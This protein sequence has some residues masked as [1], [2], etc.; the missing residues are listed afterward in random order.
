[1]WVRH[2]CRGNNRSDELPLASAGPGQASA[3]RS[4]DGLD[5]RCSWTCS[6]CMCITEE[7]KFR[8]TKP[9]C[10]LSAL[11]SSHVLPSDRLTSNGPD[12][13]KK[14]AAKS[15]KVLLYQ[16]HTINSPSHRRRTPSISPPFPR[17]IWGSPSVSHGY[18]PGLTQMPRGWG[19][20]RPI[21][22]AGDPCCRH[23]G[24]ACAVV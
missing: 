15:S 1:M 8:A 16:P 22:N 23:L 9:L 24:R 17:N 19:H 11:N 14:Q 2:R 21:E 12:M 18:L 13:P 6:P 10:S 20:T 3:Q 4:D 5:G 7:T